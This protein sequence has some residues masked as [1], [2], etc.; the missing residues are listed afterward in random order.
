MKFNG[1][2]TILMPCKDPH[3]EFFDQALHSVLEQ[4]YKHW[5]LIII[6]D[7]SIQQKTSKKLTELKT[8]NDERIAVLEN[9]TKQIS[10]ALNTGMR[11]SITP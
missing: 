4:S 2:V 11:N 7:H 8:L 9:D 3:I 1:L 6:N 10:G 5:K